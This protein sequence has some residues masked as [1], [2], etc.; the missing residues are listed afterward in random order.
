MRK[1][2]NLFIVCFF[3]LVCSLPSQV[4]AQA[5]T[6]KK[7]T[8]EF[9]NERLPSVLK[10]LEKISGYKIL[11]TYDDIKKFTVSGSVK[12]KSIEQTLDIILANKSLEY[13]IED[14][15]ITIA[16]KG[17]SKQAKVF[18]VKGVVISGDDNQPL[19]GATVVIKGSKSGVLTDIDGKFS[20][21]NVSNKSTLQ[22]SYIGMKPQNLSPAPMMNVTLMPDVQTLTEVVVTGMQKMD[23]R[24]FTGATN[25]L[26][27]DEVKLDGLPDISRGLEGR[28][29]GVSVQ[30]VSGTFGT[31][32]KIRVRGATSIYGSSKPLWV[33][34]GVIM[35]DAIDVGAD[36]LSSGN[37]ETLI[38]SAIAG[39]NSDDIESF[40]ILK[41]GSATSIYGARAMAGVIVVT[42]KK[43]KVGVQKINYTGEFTTRMIPT[44]KEFN[45]MNSQEQMGVYKELQQKG[46]LNNSDTYRVKDSGVYGRLYKLINTFNETTGQFA[47]VNTPEAR[48]AYL[49]EAELRNTD[50]FDVLF[51]NN[52]MQN[53]SV[54][55]SSGTEKTSFY[56]SLSAMIDPGW[57][58][59]SDVKRYTANLNAS[60]SILKNLSFNLITNASYR[61]QK[62]PGTLSSEVNPA[63][64][65]VTRQFD[66][67]PYSYALNTSRAMDPSADYIANYAPFNILSELNNNYI[68]MNVVDVK[69]QGE[70][71][72][73]ILSGLEAS[74]LASVKYQTSSQ[75]HHILDDSN[76]ATAYRTGM[77]DATIRDHNNLLYT[78]PE[79]P[80]A[81]PI[82]ILPEGGIYQRKDHRMRGL[83]FRGTLSWN[84]LFAEK[85]ITNF[86][87][88]FE[89]NELRRTP[90]SF[91]GWGMQ[92]TMGEIPSYV[93]QYFK[94]GIEAGNNYYSLS[95]TQTRSVAGFINAT[96][97][98]SGRYI[99]NGTFRHEGTNRMGKSRSSRWLPTWNVSGAWNAH[100]E[101]FFKIVQPF[102]SHFT[103]KASYSLTAD[104]G[105]DYV[106]NSQAIIK[107]YSPYRPFT[108]VQETGL[109][110]ENPENSELTY[111]KKHELNIGADMGF[112]ENRINFAVDWY[113]RN[114]YDLIGIIATEAVGGTLY[115]YANIASM[116]S[117]GI[118]FTLSTQN[119]KTKK[120]NW[121]SDFIFS[122]SKNEVTDLKSRASVMEL[123][124]GNGFARQGYPVRGLFSIPFV[125][126]DK[127]GLPLFNINGKITSTEF[128]FQTRDNIDYLKYE[129]PTDPTITGSFGNIFS[130]KNFKLN[131]FM[132]YSF[133]NVV[134]LDPSFSVQYSDLTTM[135]R[136]FKNR[137]TVPGDENKT[138]IPVIVSQRQYQL[139]TDLR[140]GYNAYNYSTER[141]AKGDFIRMKEISISYDF[142]KTWLAPI[143]ITNLSLKLQATNLFLVYADK[144]LNGQDP[145]FF[146]TGGV[147]SPVPRQFTLTLRLGL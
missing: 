124:S 69:F 75:E 99:I 22:F 54:S 48:N 97:S 50:W 12:E 18:N 33:V 43:G 78:D 134:R 117:K 98:Y 19:I 25:Q 80:Y 142:P 63:S 9:S 32:P 73:K 29:A 68:D 15:F 16:P 1:S 121:S 64:G 89:V 104:R 30:N 91:Q 14:Q 129:G 85:H 55:F 61:E 23:K 81:L 144:K 70:L 76:Q 110:V 53:H 125:G 113:K 95:H 49:R 120:F 106:T 6:Q 74:A 141:I 116:E 94:K 59:R 35:E 39:L 71:K 65:E 128:D 51:S 119:I 17:P 7:I 138:N 10:R 86:F 114:N 52:I 127:N 139:N 146:N 96:Y 111:E 42:T 79:N 41:D 24:L 58:K 137:W 103:L 126:L 131:I 8:I 93:Y 108:N 135:P 136:E 46:W 21:E 140:R 36:D 122:H 130:Y 92:Y 37:A 11:F 100:E 66:I 132:T 28:A 3:C 26:S 34:D 38:S 60:Y 31:A 20:I 56:A 115:K 77:D 109:Y 13:H 90:T 112:L 45:L 133:G 84:H 107:S 145:E 147:A 118:E 82:S 2:W 27:A 123:I 44:Y 143:K 62:A 72:W 102:V 83:D 4:K 47:I 105:P 57:Y 87:G 67:N 40:Q 88:G 101:S 5:Q